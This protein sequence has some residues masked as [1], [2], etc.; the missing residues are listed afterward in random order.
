MKICSL[1]HDRQTETGKIGA[2][3]QI[4]V[5]NLPKKNTNNF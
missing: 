2:F 3:L 5:A 4:L 1:V